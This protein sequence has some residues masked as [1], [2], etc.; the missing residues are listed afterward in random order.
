M[1][2]YILMC[3]LLL[4]LY[5]CKNSDSPAGSVIHINPSA[6]VSG[7]GSE[8]KPFKYWSEVTFQPGYTYSQK[9]GTIA[10]EQIIIDNSGTA[11]YPIVISAYGTGENPII[12]GSELETG[13]SFKTGSIYSK[14]FDSSCI[15]GMIAQDGTALTFIAWNTNRDTTFTGASAGSF[16][17]DYNTNKLYAWCTSGSPSDHQ[18]E[19]SRR[20]R[21][22]AGEGISNVIIENIRVQYVSL[23]GIDIGACG[24]LGTCSG[25]ETCSNI[26]IK[27]CTVTKCG[28]IW[29]GAPYNFHLG[30]GIQFA[31]GAVNCRV[32]NCTITDIFDS[33]VSPQVYSDGQSQSGIVITGT[34]IERC[35]FAGIEIAGLNNLGTSGSINGVKIEKVSVSES[36][37]GWSGDRHE[38]YSGNVQAVGIKIAA[39]PG[40]DLS[41]ITIDQSSITDCKGNA[42]WLYGDT[43]TV[44]INR[45][46][47]FNNDGNG[48]AAMDNSTGLTLKLVTTAS[49]IYNNVTGLLF[50]V[51]DGNGY[52]IYNNTFY[53]NSISLQVNNNDGSAVVKNN[54]FS[55]AGLAHIVCSNPATGIIY[56]YNTYHG[57][58]SVGLIGYNAANYTNLTDFQNGTVH[59]DNGLDDDPIFTDSSAGNFSLLSGSPCIGQGD[60]SAGVTLDF[61]GNSYKNPPSIGADEYY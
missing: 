58:G 18:M 27:N 19:V 50:D 59:E 4:I 26:T 10:R 23:V 14:T 30:N 24:I 15:L 9:R 22:I 11:D 25:G 17:I 16:S 31:N 47:I 53:N 35:G 44:T 21:G 8:D 12:Q 5:S 41:N 49:L 32:E 43:G 29:F 56:N 6:A 54:I 60:S 52:T 55:A 39:D 37:K 3:I 46:K 42:V 36:G 20:N 51:K 13:W 61:N 7:D 38:E 57:T 33:G 34:T 2:Y 48:I 28:G 45:T 40:S 1:K